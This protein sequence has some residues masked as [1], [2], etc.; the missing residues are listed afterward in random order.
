MNSAATQL[1]VSLAVLRE[2][3]REI[4]TGRERERQR[5]RY[6]ENNYRIHHRIICKLCTVT[7]SRRLSHWFMHTR[8]KTIVEGGP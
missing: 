6:R 7:L 5:E 1:A 3:E 4:E 2:R 8:N